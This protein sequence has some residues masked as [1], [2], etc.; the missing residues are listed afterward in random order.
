[1]TLFDMPS[2][3]FRRTDDKPSYTQRLTLRR[4]QSLERG[5]HPATHIELLSEGGTCGG[6]VHARSH[7]PGNRHT[8]WKCDLLPM[9]FGPATDIRLSWPACIKF[10]A[11]A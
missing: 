8:Y 3:D 11:L 4:R 2:P 10:E 9:T 7:R 1:M 5:I 6:C